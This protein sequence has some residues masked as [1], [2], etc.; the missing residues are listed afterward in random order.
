MHSIGQ[1]DRSAL[2]PLIA[3][4]AS[5]DQ[6]LA[7]DAATALGMI[8]DKRAIPH[9]TALAALPDSSPNVRTAA[10]DAIVRLTG[11]PFEQQIRNPRTGTHGR[12]LAV[13]SAPGRTR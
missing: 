13:S 7:G 6:A 10:K 9:L 1:L 2:P 4:L 12:G 3:V 8:G 5:P 11:Q